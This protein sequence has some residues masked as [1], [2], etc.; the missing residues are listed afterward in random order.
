MFVC[1]VE[2]QPE[3]HT[4][5]KTGLMKTRFSA[6]PLFECSGAQQQVFFFLPV[7]LR[8]LLIQYFR[9]H[10]F[11]SFCCWVERW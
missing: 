10:L 2:I 11:F 6:A 1:S 3:L 7:M 4:Q 8:D 9:F 5:Q